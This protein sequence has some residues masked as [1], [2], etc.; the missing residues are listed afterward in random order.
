MRGIF[1]G[2]FDPI[3]FGHLRPALELAEGLG[4][5]EL[6][7]IPSAQPP[8]RGTPEVTAAQRLTMVEL[9]CAGEWRF[10][11]DDRELRRDGPSYTLLTLQELRQ[12]WGEHE[13]VV[14]CLGLDAFL[15]LPSW[16]QWERILGHCHIVVA[17]RPGWHIEALAEDETIAALLDTHRVD[18]VAE[19]ETTS[20]GG[21]WF[22][23]VSQ[24]AISATEIRQ[25]V[26]E[27]QSIRYLTPQVVVEYIAGEGLYL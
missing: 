5:E 1:G 18:S 13:S 9:A 20:A 11:V 16:H 2:T 10:V 17:H 21:I 15:G 22:Q 23:P 27:G 4:L 8:H 12:A 6:R 25:R 3:H 19:L 24:L 26:R 14:L 7:I